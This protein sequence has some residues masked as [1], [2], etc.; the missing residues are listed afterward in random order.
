MSSL[1]SLPSSKVNAFYLSVCLFV[2]LFVCLFAWCGLIVWTMCAPCAH[3]L[4]ALRPIS[5]DDCAFHL[6]LHLKMYKNNLVSVACTQ[7]DYAFAQ[8]I[9]AM[10]SGA[11]AAE[12]GTR[13]H[14]HKVKIKVQKKRESSSQEAVE[15]NRA[16]DR[17]I[18]KHIHMLP[19]STTIAHT[20]THTCIRARAQQ[21]LVRSNCDAFAAEPT[22]THAPEKRRTKHREKF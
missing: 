5:A 17:G 6:T 4:R 10:E 11:S 16:T 7:C 20:H 8:R 3:Q 15:T 21:S 2:R 1:S 12:M 22:Q 18:H 9:N 19:H 14:R 13:H